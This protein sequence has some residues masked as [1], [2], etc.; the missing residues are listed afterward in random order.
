MRDLSETQ[1]RVIRELLVSRPGS[2][3]VKCAAAGVPRSTFQQVRK[4]AYSAGWI[5]RRYIPDPSSIGVDRIR[6]EIGQPF[7]EKRANLLGDLVRRA[8]VVLV[9]DCPSTIVSVSFERSRSEDGE[10]AK[11]DTSWSRRW[12]VTPSPSGGEV[13]A[14]FD[15]E[16]AWSR[17]ALG[18]APKA[19]PRGMPPRQDGSPS[20]S[21]R[22]RAEDLADLV[23]RPILGSG[24]DGGGFW[25]FGGGLPSRL[26]S[27]VD[28]L[29]AFPWTVPDLAKIPGF[30]RRE[31]ASVVLTSGTWAS[32]SDGRGLFQQLVSRCRATP[33]LYAFDA[34][35]VVM[36]FLA[37]APTTLM[38]GRTHITA[39]LAESLREIEVIREPIGSISP[40]INHRYD[41]LVG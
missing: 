23:R 9:W 24:D 18:E 29:H 40:V 4:L 25:P 30:A 14:Y 33:F 31:I 35:R 2:D 15:Y 34:K 41:R 7:A 12:V 39:V 28:N 6:V 32:G 21:K 3:R 26:Q 22:F 16:G 17:W 10:R 36:G 19:Y 27:L 11:E 13:V 20:P 8:E 38:V 37:P 1:A 5:V